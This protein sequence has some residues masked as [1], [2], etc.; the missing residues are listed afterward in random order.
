Y[1]VQ[2]AMADGRA[3]VY[4]ATRATAA[5]AALDRFAPQRSD[6]DALPPAT[7]DMEYQSAVQAWRQD[8]YARELQRIVDEANASPTTIPA[9]L[10]TAV[11][12]TADPGQ[13]TPEQVSSAL[14]LVG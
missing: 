11:A 8:P 6:Y 2:K 9:Y 5:Q 14:A 13:F 7:A 4:N 1:P 3:E 12:S 10:E